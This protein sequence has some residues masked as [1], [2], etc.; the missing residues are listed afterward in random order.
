MSE[1]RLL[2]SFPP[3]PNG[4]IYVNDRVSFRTEG[5]ERVISVHGVVFAHYDVGDRAAEA[6]AMITLWESEYASQIEIARSFGYSARSLR[7][8]QKRL[9]AGGIGALI[10]GPGRPSGGS[11]NAKERGR[12]QTILHLKAK[13]A[14]NRTI[15]GKLGLSEKAIRKRLRRLGWRPHPEPA[16]SSLLFQEQTNGDAFPSPAVSDPPMDNP[17]PECSRLP[18]VFPERVSCWRFR[19]WWSAAC[20]P[21]LARS[22]AQSAQPFTDYARP[23]SLTFSWHY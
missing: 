20:C 8:Y 22:T 14:S 4:T 18:I 11:K 15:A 12:D 9:E 3:P 23:W 6:Y 1:Q 16:E 21:W 5:T 19:L 13:G 7:R 10:R 17:A 2:L